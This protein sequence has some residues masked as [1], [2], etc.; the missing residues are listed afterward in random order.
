MC[1]LTRL[2]LIPL[3]LGL[4]ACQNGGTPAAGEPD[5]AA[6]P[7]PAQAQAPPTLTPTLPAEAAAP[8]TPFSPR[9]TG[10]PM[11][12]C[13][14]QTLIRDPNATEVSL[15]RPVTPTDWVRGPADAAVTIIEYADFQCPFCGE[16]APIL[17]QLEADYPADIRVVFRHFPLLDTHDKAAL[18]L[19]AAETA[20]FQGDFWGMHDLLYARQAD[21]VNL[22][23]E[24]FRTWVT[25]RAGELGLN[26]NQ[27]AAG[28]I[29]QTYI[30][31]AQQ[32]Y[33]DG[34]SLGIPGTP[35]LIINGLIYNGPTDYDNL[36]II[37]RLFALQKRQFTT[38]PP[39]II[40]T[41]QTY[42]AT[43]ETLKGNIVVELYP[44][45][46]PIAV[47]NF[48]FL[49]LNGW[50]DNITF[51][52]VEPGFVAQAGDPSGTGFGGPGY[53]FI[54]ETNDLKFDKAGVF[55]MGNAGP[56]SN[57]SHFF[58]TLGP[59]PHLD[60]GYTIFGQVIEGMDVA[61]SLAPR[62]AE[63]GINQPPG[64]LIITIRIEER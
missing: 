42:L 8:D 30:E 55:A 44:D 33:T 25:E 48:I 6:Q 16:L 41:A 1:R 63:G 3:L 21:W 24:D 43:I 46:A 35:F 36:S 38:C 2:I 20:G 22:P 31:M 17:A 11:P 4:A 5:P 57:G 40:D 51:H 12:G 15:F 10:E 18:A 47:N 58:I 50:Y 34:A 53:A 45:K 56:D 19:A 13:T 49:A 29:S 62:N 52:R 9:D 39:M 60:G 61:L 54:N 14:V 59:A 26:Q 27:F 37:V 7:P 28:L 32:A 64:D 23:V